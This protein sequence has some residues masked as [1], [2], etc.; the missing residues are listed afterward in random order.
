V[1]KSATMSSHWLIGTKRMARR[2]REQNIK[3]KF[4]ENQ[5]HESFLQVDFQLMVSISAR[6]REREREPVKGRSL[7]V[8]R[9]FIF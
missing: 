6:E 4:T 5:F 2:I 1:Y 8:Q 9:G 7:T 3:T